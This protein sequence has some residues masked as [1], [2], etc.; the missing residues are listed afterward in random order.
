MA[1]PNRDV[2]VKVPQ[3]M[4]A[5]TSEQITNEQYTLNSREC[6]SVT[7]DEECVLTRSEECRHYLVIATRVG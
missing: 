3:A 2:G 6:G 4:F 1:H 5:Q 7:L